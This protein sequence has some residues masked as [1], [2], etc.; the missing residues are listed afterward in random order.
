MLHDANHFGFGVDLML[1]TKC[2]VNI[3]TEVIIGKEHLN[4]FFL[5][6]DLFSPYAFILP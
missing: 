4:C 3:G 2:Q 1:C 5:F 6:L